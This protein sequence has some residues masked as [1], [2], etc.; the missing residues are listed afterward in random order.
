MTI[1]QLFFFKISIVKIFPLIAFHAKKEKKNM[2]QRSSRPSYPFDWEYHDSLIA[3]GVVVQ[4]QTEISGP[5]LSP[6]TTEN[7]WVIHP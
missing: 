4:L 1:V 7:F 6:Q 2:S 5:S 3:Y